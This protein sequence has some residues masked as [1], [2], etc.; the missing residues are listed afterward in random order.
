M[1]RRRSFAAFLIAFAAADP[2]TAVITESQV[3]FGT[4]LY[5]SL[6]SSLAASG[7]TLVAGSPYVYAVSPLWKGEVSVYRRSGATFVLEQTLTA[8]DGAALD[9]F[10]YDVAISGDVLVVG[11]LRAQPPL[12]A[13]AYVFRRTGTTWIEEQILVASCSN[14]ALFLCRCRET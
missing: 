11:T 8:S 12:G 6:G 2:S 3:I 14:C 10:G 9:R 7:D 13:T 1:T 5:G 4:V